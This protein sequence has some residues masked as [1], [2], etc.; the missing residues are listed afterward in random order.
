MH[1]CPVNAYERNA[2]PTVP[3]NP[4]AYEVMLTKLLENDLVMFHLKVRGRRNGRFLWMG[5]EEPNSELFY[6]IRLDII[7]DRR[8]WGGGGGG[9]MSNF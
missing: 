9:G 1:E 5:G 6:P 8:G 7:S 3:N 2:C 4:A